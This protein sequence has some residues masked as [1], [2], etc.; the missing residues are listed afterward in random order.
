MPLVTSFS[1]KVKNYNYKKSS[2][3]T[4]AFSYSYVKFKTMS[5]CLYDLSILNVTENLDLDFKNASPGIFNFTAGILT[6]FMN[7]CFVIYERF[8]ILK[9]FELDFV[10]FDSDNDK[11]PR[12]N[13]LVNTGFIL[14]RDSRTVRRLI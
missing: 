6:S 10:N 3:L 5:G 12:K 1:L 14:S 9:I 2:H 4:V 13:I 8:L 7:Y 11:N